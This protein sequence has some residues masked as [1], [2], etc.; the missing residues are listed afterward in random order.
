[1]EAECK[2][3]YKQRKKKSTD[4]WNMSFDLQIFSK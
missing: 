2:K 3:K 4:A 1:M